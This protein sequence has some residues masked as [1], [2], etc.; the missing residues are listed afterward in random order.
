MV[1]KLVGAGWTLN[2][3]HRTAWLVLALLLLPAIVAIIVVF[4]AT[5]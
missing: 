1:P 2:F 5:G 4:I 3:A